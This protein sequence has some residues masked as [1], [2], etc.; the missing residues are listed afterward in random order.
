LI[1]V[2]IDVSQKKHDICI[3]DSDGTILIEQLMIENNKKGFN[4][5]CNAIDKQEGGSIKDNIRIALEDTGHYSINLLY[6][7]RNKGYS[8]Y[9]Y[10]L[11]LVKEFAK[12]ITL[13]KT[14]TDKKDAK[15]IARRLMSDYK[16]ERFNADKNLIDLKFLTRN[17]TRLGR[18]QSE[19]KVQYVRLIDLMFPELSTYATSVHHTY[20]YSLLKINQVHMTV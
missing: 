2:G 15:L 8:V 17:R 3:I 12:S 11:L 20:V 13:R 4:A 7:L 14:K 10:N 18:Y 16:A 19:G 6:F 1:N 9:T 5:L